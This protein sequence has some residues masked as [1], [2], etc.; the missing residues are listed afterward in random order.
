MMITP[1]E[2]CEYTRDL[3]DPVPSG[4]F[5]WVGEISGIVV[6]YNAVDN[7]LT[8]RGSQ[9]AEDWIRNF[10]AV[11]AWDDDIGFCETGFLL[12]VND[13]IAAILGDIKPGVTITGHSLGGAHA[14]LIA[15]KLAKREFDVAMLC[16]FGSPKAGFINHARIIQKSGMAHSSH[17]NR[18][19]IVPTVPLTIEPCFDYVHTEPW[20]SLNAAPAI[21]DLEALRDHSIDLYLKGLS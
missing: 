14:R 12:G 3:Y 16:T 11:P 13:V 15:A 21:D 6:G 5:D 10:I 4:R 20:I 2:C 8:C 19:D 7:V 1:L 17:R 18:N 9:T